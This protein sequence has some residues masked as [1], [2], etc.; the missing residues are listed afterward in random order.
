[1]LH[2]RPFYQ[3]RTIEVGADNVDLIPDFLGFEEG[4]EPDIST[5]GLEVALES[6]NRDFAPNPSRGSL[7]RLKVTR[8]FGA[9]DS[10][11]SWTNVD[12]SFAKYWDLSGSN[13]P[14]AHIQFGIC[15]QVVQID[16]RT[17]TLVRCH[18]VNHRCSMLCT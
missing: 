7:T 4:D 16:L 15:S 2:I 8:D 6:D 1:V 10:F 5:N 9:F 13:R 3:R 12:F 14:E 17:M 18:R 11:T